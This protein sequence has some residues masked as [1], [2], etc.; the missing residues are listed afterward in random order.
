MSAALS[1]PLTL[2]PSFFK[3]MTKPTIS[4]VAEQN[5]DHSAQT[6]YQ[7]AK[8]TADMNIQQREEDARIGLFVDVRFQTRVHGEHLSGGFFLFFCFC[9]FATHDVL[10]IPIVA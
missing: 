3:T 2:C 8:G 1:M 6:K 7:C 10:L 4:Q 5:A 9:S